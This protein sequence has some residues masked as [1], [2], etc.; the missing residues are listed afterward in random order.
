MQKKLFLEFNTT[1]HTSKTQADEAIDLIPQ[2]EQQIQTAE[3]KTQEAVDNLSGAKTD[4]QLARDI[5]QE[6]KA[7][8]LEASTVRRNIFRNISV[9]NFSVDIKVFQLHLI[10][11]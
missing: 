6:A 8:A 11:R 9:Y 3:E 2:I 1:V 5:A 7:I 10:I 4:A